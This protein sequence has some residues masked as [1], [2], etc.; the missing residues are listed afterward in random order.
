MQNYN[1]LMLVW[2][3]CL[4]QNLEREVKSRIIG[5]KTQM[6]SFNFFYGINLGFK[7]YSITDNLSKALQGE[8]MSAVES[9]RTAELSIK[10]LEGMRSTS[11]ADAFYETTKQKAEKHQFIE[12]PTLPR[13]RKMPNYKTLEQYF[14]VDGLSKG[15]ASHH[16]S[17]TKEYFRGIYFEVLDTI[18]SVIKDRFDQPSFEAYATIE[19]LLL[20]SIEG[21]CITNEIEFLTDKYGD[22]DVDVDSLEIELEVFKTIFSQAKPLCFKDIHENL[23]MISEGEKKLIPNVLNVCELLIVNPA[24]SC[25]AERSFSTARRLKSWLRAT[26]TNRRFNSLAILNTHKTLTDK[27]DFVQIGN[28][29]VSKHSE[30]FQ[31]FGKFVEGD[32]L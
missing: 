9:H 8:S 26:M 3:E 2:D 19:S 10:T 14:N 24:T 23:K 28:E 13:K 5:C 17:D 18:T 4:E 25:T 20:K 15:S 1:Q 27:L 7:L 29:F 21:C 16:P 31:Q 22:G 6:E 12:P 11:H 32:F 30:R